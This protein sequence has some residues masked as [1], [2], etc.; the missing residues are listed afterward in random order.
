MRLLNNPSPGQRV[1]TMTICDY[2]V[3]G[4][5]TTRIEISIMLYIL[6]SRVH[7]GFLFSHSR[8]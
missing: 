1:M 2:D 4:F 7:F 8:G 6:S 3:P 5:P